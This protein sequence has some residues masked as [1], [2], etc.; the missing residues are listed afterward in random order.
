MLMPEQV[1]AAIERSN[2]DVGG[3]IIEQSDTEFFV[4]SRGYLGSREGKHAGLGDSSDA[5]MQDLRE[6]VVAHSPDGAAIRLS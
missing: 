3:R 4:R 6:V 1:Q 2:N 5:V